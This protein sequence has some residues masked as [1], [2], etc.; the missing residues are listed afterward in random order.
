M[1]R[2]KY[3]LIILLSVLFVYSCNPNTGNS[4]GD[5]QNTE[6]NENNDNNESSEKAIIINHNSINLAKVPEEWI[7]KA[8]EKFK[9]AYSHTSHGSQIVT[10]M[11]ALSSYSD[12]SVSLKNVVASLP[13]SFTYSSWGFA[14][15]VFFADYWGDEAEGYDLG[16]NGDLTWSN[17]TKM[18]LSRNGNDRN[19]VMWSWCGGVSDNDERGIKAYLDAMNKLEK[20]YPDIK[21]IYMTGHLDGT[22]VNG[23]LH[24]RNEQIRIYCEKNG[25]ILFDFADIESYDPNGKYFLDRGA[26]DGCNYDSGNWAEQW[27]G[28]N[29]D[30]ELARLAKSGNCEEC[31]HS[32]RLNCIMKGRAFWYMMARMAGWNGN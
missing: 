3:F 20:D 1:R 32:Q 26:D 5:N 30:S 2:L 25:K 21:F 10:G 31:A 16:H 28:A 29:S 4:T 6:N 22:G 17:A 13:I 23:N 7:V 15:G 8:K 24:K 18:L 11:K 9:I 12:S 14:T 27:I 19:V